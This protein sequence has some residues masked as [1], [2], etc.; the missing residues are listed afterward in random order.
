MCT[1]YCVCTWLHI[2]CSQGHVNLDLLRRS[3]LTGTILRAALSKGYAI[4]TSYHTCICIALPT[5]CRCVPPILYWPW[6]PFNLF[7]LRSCAPT[8]STSWS[9]HC[10]RRISLL[11]Q[12]LVYPILFC[13]CLVIVFLT[14]V[15][16]I[17]WPCRGYRKHSFA[18]TYGTKKIYVCS[19][20]TL[21]FNLY[22]TKRCTIESSCFSHYLKWLSWNTTS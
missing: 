5:W 16:V 1:S 2:T 12:E 3:S 20:R 21:M 10:W 7:L 9:T 19:S 15:W 6:P 22:R 8:C 13:I 14:I 11:K 17:Q 18:L 4:L